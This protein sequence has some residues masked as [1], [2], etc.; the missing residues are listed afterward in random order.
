MGNSNSFESVYQGPLLTDELMDDYLQL[1]YLSRKEISRI[2]KR[3]QDLIGEEEFTVVHRVTWERMLEA[4]PEI[5]ANPFVD[6]LCEVFSSKNDGHV[7]FEDML[8]LFSALSPSCP[9]ESKAKW[10]F[11]IFDFN[12]SNALEIEDLHELI[13]R[14]TNG[15]NVKENGKF[16]TE[17]EKEHIVDIVS[18][19]PIYYQLFIK[20]F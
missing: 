3:M 16:L 4:F 9:T 2:H 6:R 13:D 8:D 17:D 7:S 11:R 19:F 1:S 14:L 18:L 10:A 20:H 15:R 12:N 5:K